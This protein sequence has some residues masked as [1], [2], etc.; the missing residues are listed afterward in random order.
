MG[1]LDNQILTEALL[2]QQDHAEYAL[3]HRRMPARLNPALRQQIIER[4]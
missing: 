3:L 4:S 1:R 2:M